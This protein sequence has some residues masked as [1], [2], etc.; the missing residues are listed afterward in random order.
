M[1]DL[2]TNNQ[3][4]PI[5]SKNEDVY[6]RATLCEDYKIYNNEHYDI[7]LSQWR[8]HLVIDNWF[9]VFNSKFICYFYSR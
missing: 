2:L 6:D 5:V 4:I 8:H 7:Q 9:N 3:K 1:T